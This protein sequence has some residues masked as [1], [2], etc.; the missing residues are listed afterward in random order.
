MDN[1]F[2][3]VALDKLSSG[4]RLIT[5]D[6]LRGAEVLSAL[7]MY[8]ANKGLKHVFR[9]LES[10]TG[11]QLINLDDQLSSM[12]VT[13]SAGYEDLAS[14]GGD[15]EVTEDQ[16]NEFGGAQTYFAEMLP[17]ILQETGQNIEK[18]YLYNTLRA[19]AIKIGSVV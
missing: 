10:V 3:K 7:P 14:I 8:P 4:Q 5:G 12:N 1:L 9:R 16:A 18:S 11:A 17:S 13:T 19:Y 15:I 6:L 2:R